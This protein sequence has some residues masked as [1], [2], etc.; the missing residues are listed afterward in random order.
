MTNDRPPIQV[1]LRA[2]DSEG[3][4]GVIE[5]VVPAGFGGPAL[6]VHPAFDEGFYVLEGELTFKVRDELITVRAGSF[7]FAPRGMPHTFANLSDKPARQLILCAPAGFE[8]YFMRLAAERAGVAPPP[9]AE[10]PVPETQPVGPPI[11]RED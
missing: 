6:H 5:T 11:G 4:L 8:R 7:A 10:G 9:E 2:E 1:R 3:R